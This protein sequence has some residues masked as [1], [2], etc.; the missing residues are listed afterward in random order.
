MQIKKGGL[1]TVS[2]NRKGKF[3]VIPIKDFDSE[4]EEFYPVVLALD[5]FVVGLTKE[6]VAGDIIPCRASLCTIKPLFN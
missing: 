2:H 3:K 1:Y 6:W 4:K 5:N